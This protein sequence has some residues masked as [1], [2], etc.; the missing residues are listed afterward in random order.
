MS[1][2]HREGTVLVEVS[3]ERLAAV[4][5]AK[6][7][8]QELQS[9]GSK[10]AEI[11][12]RAVLRAEVDRVSNA[13]SSDPNIAP[14]DY[15]VSLVAG[16]EDTQE[17]NKQKASEHDEVSAEIVAAQLETAVSDAEK[18]RK[19][20]KYF[21]KRIIANNTKLARDYEETATDFA[22]AAGKA[23]A[24]ASREIAR[25]RVESIN[26]PNPATSLGKIAQDKVTDISESQMAASLETKDRI[27]YG[28]E[29]F[30]AQAKAARVEAKEAASDERAQEARLTDEPM[31]VEET[32]RKAKPVENVVPNAEVN[33]APVPE[34]K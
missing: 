22:R 15:L 8:G 7:T 33:K 32:T 4:E 26:D 18:L 21:V 23:E 13:N 29:S 10:G 25:L 24:N 31:R 5:E 11:V 2:V 9:I 16:V 6:R 3:D 27:I 19:D 34:K 17:L 12:D 1:N 30:K 28:E 20:P 14:P